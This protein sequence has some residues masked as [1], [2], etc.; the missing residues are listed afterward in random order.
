MLNSA[1]MSQKQIG[2]SGLVPSQSQLGLFLAIQLKP[3]FHTNV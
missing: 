2:K 1:L 3:Q